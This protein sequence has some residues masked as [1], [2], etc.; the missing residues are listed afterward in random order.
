LECRIVQYRQENKILQL[1]YKDA[2]KYYILSNLIV[3][4][5]LSSLA[6]KEYLKCIENDPPLIISKYRNMDI[7]HLY[8]MISYTANISKYYKDKY[9]G[10]P[11]IKR[12][13]ELRIDFLN[14]KL[15]LD[16]NT[17]L[18]NRFIRNSIEH[19]AER[20]DEYFYEIDNKLCKLDITKFQ[21]KKIEKDD[22]GKILS[23]IILFHEIELPITI[24]YKEINN[25]HDR[26]L[27]IISKYLDLDFLMKK[28]NEH[29]I[30]YGYPE[31]NIS[32]DEKGNKI[33]SI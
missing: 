20:I 28:R 13:S 16:V 4:C 12:L 30:K 23:I 29:A 1:K 18:H 8:N 32:T 22:N 21:G 25:L 33:Y 9:Q 11:N 26:A 2:F 24:L 3:N 10:I 27:K 19:Y 31:V 7:Y 5:E 14:K 17:I 6:Y 15:P